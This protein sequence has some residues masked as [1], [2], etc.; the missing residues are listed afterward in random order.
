MTLDALSV[1]FSI[2]ML[3]IALILTCIPYLT[4]KTESFGVSIPEM[5]YDME[6]IQMIRKR[7]VRSM[8]LV[9]VFSVGGFLWAGTMLTP[10]EETLSMGFAAF[11]LLTIIISF[12]V[13]LKFHIKMKRIKK[14]ANWT[15]DRTQKVLVRTDFREQ[16]LTWSNAW[17]AIPFVITLL[18]ALL[19]ALFYDRLPDV[20]PMK[21][22]FAGEV[23][24]SVEK[25]YRTVFILP[26]MQSYLILLFIFI[27]TIIAK[28][29]QQL[30]AEDPEKSYKQVTLFRRR[31]SLFLLFT[32]T[33]L[34]MMFSFIQWSYFQPANQHLVTIVSLVFSGIIM[35]AAIALSFSTGQGG[36]RIQ[37]GG[38]RPSA[39]SINRDDDIHWKLGQIYYN[40]NDQALFLEKRFG[41]GWTV[42]FARPA[43]W[44]F[45][46]GIIATAAGI[47]ILLML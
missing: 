47:P 45:V 37:T 39:D 12:G 33:L 18:T 23:T 20:L 31:W 35:S 22:N 6:S 40:P 34:T 15:H 10:N 24:Q 19:T 41:I 5:V 43:A 26:I 9:T 13:Y 2:V 7:Y 38:S 3:P 16:Q 21:V 36:S 42:N 44:L 8:L 30:N 27:N 29:K 14:E 1:V 25:S 32:S 17:Y 46:I 28:A 4:R 11:T